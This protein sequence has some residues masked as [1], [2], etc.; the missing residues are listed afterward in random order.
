MDRHR[1]RSAASGATSRSTRGATRAA[2]CLRVHDLQHDQF[3]CR[4][5]V[6]E[7]HDRAFV[8]AQ[9]D[10]EDVDAR[11]EERDELSVRGLPQTDGS[12]ARSRNDH[13]VIARDRT[14]PHLQQKHQHGV[15][16]GL[17]Y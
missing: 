8:A 15:T 14:A 17:D 3:P 12:V 5:L 9:S 11:V 7:R 10:G 13:L 1:R 2:L 6:S 16:T 4:E